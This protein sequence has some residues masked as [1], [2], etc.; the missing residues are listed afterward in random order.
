MRT[1]MKARG[2]IFGFLEHLIEQEVQNRPSATTSTDAG[3]DH[4]TPADPPQ[5]SAQ[6][7]MPTT[8]LSGLA[9]EMFAHPKY[10]GSLE[11]SP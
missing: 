1:F 9:E 6:Q 4:P 10:M 7:S 11:L 3:E 2:Q 5:A 8:A